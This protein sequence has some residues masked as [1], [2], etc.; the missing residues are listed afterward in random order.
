MGPHQFDVAQAGVHLIK[1]AMKSGNSAVL[2]LY[3]SSRTAYVSA[4]VNWRRWP[5]DSRVVRFPAVFGGGAA[6][7][8]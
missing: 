2:A 7:H 3:A 5:K 4:V 8:M 1:A 6:Y